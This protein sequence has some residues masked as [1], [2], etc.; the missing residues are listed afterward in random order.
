VAGTSNRTVEFDLEI[1]TFDIDFAGHV[2]NITYLRWLEIGR[3]R[4]LADAGLPIEELM[5]RDLAPVLTSTEITYRVALKLG[6]PVRLVLALTELRAASATLNFEVRSGSRLAATASQRG[7]F[8]SVASG[9]PRRI[10]PDM[11]AKLLPYL[12][13]GDGSVTGSQENRSPN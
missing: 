10:T 2:S 9:K 4:L 1:Y 12:R 13:P 5:R 6:D 7:L 3:L 11:R 8:I